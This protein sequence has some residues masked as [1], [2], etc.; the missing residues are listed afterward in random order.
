MP[1]KIEEDEYVPQEESEEGIQDVKVELEE[2]QKSKK[3]AIRRAIKLEVALHNARSDL[4]KYKKRYRKVKKEMSRMKASSSPVATIEKVLH[5]E[6]ERVVIRL[7]NGQMYVAKGDPDLDLKEGDYVSLYRREMSILEKIPQLIDKEIEKMKLMEIP[8]ENY[9]DVGGLD[10]ELREVKEVVET[11]ILDPEAFELFNIPTPKGILLHGLP[12]TGKTLIAKAVANAANAKFLYLAAPELVQKFIGEG[13]R[14]VREIF[15]LARESED[16]VIIFIDEIDAIAAK[17]RS[18]SHSGERE[19][20]R[21]LMQLLAEMDGFNKNSHVRLISATNRIDMLDEAILRPGRF[22]RIIKLPLPS[23]EAR[24]RIF[25]IHLRN[26]PTYHVKI[27]D[28]AKRTEDFSGADIKAVCIEAAMF[29]I[30]K[31]QEGQ[32]RKTITHKDL[33]KA[34]EKVQKKREQAKEM[35]L[36]N[37]KLFYS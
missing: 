17:R 26:R 27:A 29:A 4:E 12:G 37:T 25:E 36:N 33:L 11:S 15:Q 30:R 28:L 16:P 9:E 34:V 6:R 19:V 2:L 24:K 31:R 14:L 32:N 5:D 7:T 23:E 21:T 8:E 10:D 1:T 18:G 20:N 3:R 13:A 22:D 35:G